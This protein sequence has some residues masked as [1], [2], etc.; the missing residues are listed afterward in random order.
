VYDTHWSTRPIFL[1]A[2]QAAAASI[3]STAQET[4]HGLVWLPDPDQPARTATVTAPAT[5]Y[6][7]NAGIVLFFLELAQATG[8]ATYLADARRGA[9]Q[10]AVTWREVLT[11]E[12]PFSLEHLNLTFTMGLS[13]TAFVLTHVWQAT[14]DVRYRDAALAITEHIV[15]AARPSGTGV[16]WIGAIWRQRVAQRQQASA[17]ASICWSPPAAL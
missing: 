4:A 13:G 15:A 14:Q 6:S 1:A 7:G 2:A 17:Q 3:R 9:D 16:A 10:I 12:L 11:F 5:I 8:D